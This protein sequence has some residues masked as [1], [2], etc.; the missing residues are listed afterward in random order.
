MSDTHKHGEMPISTR[1]NKQPT[2]KELQEH[3]FAELKA[4]LADFNRRALAATN[5]DE[6]LDSENEAID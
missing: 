1:E 3:G 5:L 6:L 4:H 2:S